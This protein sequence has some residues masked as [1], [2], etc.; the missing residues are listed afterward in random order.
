MTMLMSLFAMA[1][2]IAA[3]QGTS[4][5]VKAGPKQALAGTLQLP[6]G[7]PR[8]TAI[9][10]PGSGPTDRDGN[11]PIGVT[12]APYRLL[13][14]DLAARGIATIRIDKRGM[15]G[16][17]AATPDANKVTID[18]YVGDIG[19]WIAAAKAQTGASCIWLVGHSEGGLVALSAA[20]EKGVCGLVLVATAG[21][22]FGQL[23]RDQLKANPANAPVLPQA[24]AALSALEA[25][26]HAD[27]SAMHPALAKG[28]F[29]PAVQDYL[30]DVM[31]RDPIA[32]L[33]AYKGRVLVVQGDHD[34]QVLVDD[35]RKL[36]AARPGVA[37]QVI[38]GMS[39]VL[40]DAPEDPAGNMAVMKR[41]DLPLSAG[42][43]D[44]IAAFMLTRR[45]G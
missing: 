20:Q 13:A 8:A 1:A 41:P 32:L 24:E 27:T 6:S 39:H 34:L 17:K 9:I 42:L 29:N 14:Q 16:S 18:D 12:A 15:F 26:K 11:N 44:Q 43:V 45:K 35:A 28:L 31:R 23:I 38:P 10:I 40:K 4:K 19:S 33:R 3:P 7:K 36:G 25:G 5:E 30:I 21:R 37:V 22:R 2:A